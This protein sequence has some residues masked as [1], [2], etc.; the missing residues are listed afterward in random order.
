MHPTERPAVLQSQPA[1]TAAVAI[2]GHPEVPEE[3]QVAMEGPGTHTQL[4]SKVRD[5]REVP[6]GQQ[7]LQLLQTLWSGCAALSVNHHPKIGQ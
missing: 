5:G 3:G 7:H 4:V 6:L 2:D 1:A